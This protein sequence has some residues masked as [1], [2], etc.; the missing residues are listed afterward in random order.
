M[1]MIKECLDVD[2]SLYSGVN[3]NDDL[4]L[5][6]LLL[7]L[8]HI[9]THLNYVSMSCHIFKTALMKTMNINNKFLTND[10]WI[11]S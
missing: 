7:L 9:F 5:I 6:L 11:I 4:L 8:F 3:I 2:T 10:L 1:M